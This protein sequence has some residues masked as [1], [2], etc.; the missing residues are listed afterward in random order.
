M[1]LASVGTMGRTTPQSWV[2][3]IGTHG[4][5]NLAKPQVVDEFD[6]KGTVRRRR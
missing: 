2:G 5:P 3:A 6:T 4:D 1:E